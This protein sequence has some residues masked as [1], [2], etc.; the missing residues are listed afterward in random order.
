M[1]DTGKT[2][3]RRLAERASVRTQ[4]DLCLSDD[5]IRAVSVDV[6]ESGVRLNIEDPLKIL[7][8]MEMNGESVVR[9]AQIVWAGKK[10]ERGMSYG[11]EYA[12]NT[13]RG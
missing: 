7:L 13:G 12:P 6:S 10:S 11:F 3:E 2:S 1:M 9:E 5:T 4:V 8:R